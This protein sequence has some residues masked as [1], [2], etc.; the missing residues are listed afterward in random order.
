MDDNSGADAQIHLIHPLGIE[1]RTFGQR[2][3]RKF[4]GTEMNNGDYVPETGSVPLNGKDG[5]FGFFWRELVGDFIVQIVFI[6]ND[7]AV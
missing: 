5:C 1:A 6:G 4:Y 7:Y 3:P 2:R